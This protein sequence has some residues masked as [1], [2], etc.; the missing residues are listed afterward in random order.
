MKN[1]RIHILI[2]AFNILLSLKIGRDPDAEF[3][4]WIETEYK[5]LDV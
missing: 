1:G 3:D 4:I 5:S 2:P